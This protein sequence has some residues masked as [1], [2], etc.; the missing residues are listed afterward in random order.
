MSSPNVEKRGYTFFNQL[1]QGR[2]THPLAYDEVFIHLFFSF[3]FL[4]CLFC[5]FCFV[6]FLFMR[7]SFFIF[8]FFVGFWKLVVG[9]HGAI[10][11]NLIPLFFFFL[12]F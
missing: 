1:G 12:V 7:I 3:C 8:F 5:L 9:A 11:R 2:N 6:L 4:F 10:R